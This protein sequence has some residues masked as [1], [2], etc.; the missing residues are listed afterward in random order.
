MDKEKDLEEM[1][2]KIDDFCS[3]IDGECDT[4]CSKCLTNFLVNAGYG[5][6]KQAVRE[7][8]EKFKQKIKR[9][10][11]I[12]FTGKTEKQ[13]YQR[14]GMEEGLQMAIEIVDDPILE[15]YGEEKT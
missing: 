10:S 15:L 13:L 4:S 2:N 6:I 1:I 11:D 12:G 7:F 14:R 5:S 9:V 3:C 8:A